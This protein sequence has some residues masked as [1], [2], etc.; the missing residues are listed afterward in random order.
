MPICWPIYQGKASNFSPTTLVGISNIFF[1]KNS[2]ITAF[3]ISLIGL[4][5]CKKEDGSPAP[6]AK[7]EWR[8]A[9][10]LF[11]AGYTEIDA[12][13][14]YKLSFR[15]AGMDGLTHGI[16]FQFTERPGAGSYTLADTATAPGQ[17]AVTLENGV[18]PAYISVGNDN[19]KVAV[20]LKTGKL[21]FEGDNIRVVRDTIPSLADTL[22]LSFDLTEY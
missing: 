15:A 19:P 22:V 17:V 16:M 18:P 13:H 3:V 2:I 11:E 14:G 4:A 20:G 8:L 9:G 7:N 5:A 1:L 12:R 6:A 21:I 10:A